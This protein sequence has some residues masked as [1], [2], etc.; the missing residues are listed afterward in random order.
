MGTPLYMSPEQGMPATLTDRSDVYQLG[1]VLYEML[2]GAVPYEV[3]AD[4]L[5]I[6]LHI[7]RLTEPPTPLRQHLPG[8]RRPSRTWSMRCCSAA[9]R[10]GRAWRRSRS[11]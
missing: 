9:R 1:L 10:P 4:S 7:Q 3:S 2:S 5:P 8:Y 11:A 6:A